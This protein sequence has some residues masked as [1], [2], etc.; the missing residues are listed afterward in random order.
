MEDAS[1]AD[2]R[3][4]ETSVQ[5]PPLDRPLR[6]ACVL[7]S[8][9]DRHPRR[10]V[11]R[12]GGVELDTNALGD[13]VLDRVDDSRRETPRAASGDQARRSSVAALLDQPSP[14]VGVGYTELDELVVENLG[15]RHLGIG[16]QPA[17]CLL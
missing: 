17:A 3:R 2:R 7:R 13:E 16:D 14:L 5:D 12:A 15:V 8:G 11:R 6:N 10:A 4:A 9:R 1:P